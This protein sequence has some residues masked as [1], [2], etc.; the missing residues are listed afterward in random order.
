L[1]GVLR[2]PP[3]IVVVTGN[4]GEPSNP[5]MAEFR[6]RMAEYLLNKGADPTVQEHHPMGAHSIIRAAVF[7]HLD[8]LKMM[9]NTMKPEA[10][11]GALND[12]PIVN[13]L[14]ALHDSVLRASMAGPDRID[15][16]VEQIRWAVANGARY[17]IEDFSGRTQRSI[18]EAIMDAKRKK[19]LL[20]ALGINQ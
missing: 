13:G 16:Y 3:L 11:A 5:D 6:K 4:N 19:L 12:I 8:I 2:Q 15:G 17:D 10:L 7:N 1:G 9:G 18:V 14:T 20:E